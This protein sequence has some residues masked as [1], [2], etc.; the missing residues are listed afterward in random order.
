MK[1]CHN[2]YGQWQSFKLV[3]WIVVQIQNKTLDYPRSNRSRSITL[4]QAATKSLRNFS[5]E[6]EL[7]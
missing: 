1:N 3:V 6:S 4:V 7:P 2:P 5:W